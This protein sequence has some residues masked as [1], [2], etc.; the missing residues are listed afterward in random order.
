MKLPHLDQLVLLERGEAGLLARPLAVL[1]RDAT[2]G[3][4][5][6]TAMQALTLTPLATLARR[7]LRVHQ[8]EQLRPPKPGRRPAPRQVR[9]SYDQLVALLQDRASLYY[10]GLSALE[11]QQMQVVVGKFHQKSLNLTRWIAIS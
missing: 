2:Q 3:R 5:P 8:Q 6:I 4:R 7:L 10:C 11:N 9:V 1:V